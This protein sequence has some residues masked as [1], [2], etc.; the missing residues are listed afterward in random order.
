MSLRDDAG[1]G[2]RVTVHPEYEKALP[3]SSQ[4]ASLNN[5]VTKLE[6]R[7]QPRLALL[8]LYTILLQERSSQLNNL[9]NK[10][11][12]YSKVH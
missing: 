3:G 1:L 7:T 5:P 8:L 9:G 11:M 6:P 4:K 2:G 10:V 12:N